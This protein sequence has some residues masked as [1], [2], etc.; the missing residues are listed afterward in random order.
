[1]LKAISTAA[2]NHVAVVHGLS[3][4]GPDRI[5]VI[6][7]DIEGRP[8]LHGAAALVA[9]ARNMDPMILEHGTHWVIRDLEI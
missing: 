5:V 3:I 9:D 2:A 8:S 7:G 1:M 4:G 6:E